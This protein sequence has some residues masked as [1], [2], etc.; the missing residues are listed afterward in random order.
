MVGCI[1]KDK[2]IILIVKY[3]NVNLKME[4]KSCV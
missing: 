3:Y 1:L 4:N 2:N